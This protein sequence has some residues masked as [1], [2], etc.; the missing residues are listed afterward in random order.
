[1]L[2]A[3]CTRGYACLNEYYDYLGIP[4]LDY[5]YQM[6]W[7]D[8]ESCDPYN[9]KSLDFNYEEIYVGENKD[10]KCWIIT[11]NLPAAFDYIL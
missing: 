2:E 5:G 9:V 1:L 11:T 8:I 7:S 6:G 10:V 3:L 4:R